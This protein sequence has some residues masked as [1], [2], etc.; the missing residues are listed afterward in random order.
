MLFVLENL[1]YV[2]P[3]INLEPNTCMSLEIYILFLPKI[4]TKSTSMNR[5]S[6]K[7]SNHLW[8]D[9]SGICEKYIL[10]TSTVGVGHD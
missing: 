6:E 7:Y 4:I 2:V 10:Q 1:H 9:F 5:N 3:K 8:N